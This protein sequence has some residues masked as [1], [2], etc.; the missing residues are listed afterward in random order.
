MGFGVCM[1]SGFPWVYPEVAFTFLF[2][3]IWGTPGVTSGTQGRQTSSDPAGHRK[4]SQISRGTG[5]DWILQ[6]WIK[7][8]GPMDPV[9]L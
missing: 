8:Q 2:S 3:R 1:A 9:L 6:K 7:N 4:W 5:L